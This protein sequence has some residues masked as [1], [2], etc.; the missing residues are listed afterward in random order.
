MRFI[1]LKCVLLLFSVI[2]VFSQNSQEQLSLEPYWRQ[3]L[4]G[5]VLSL[6]SYQAQS[7]VVAL[8]G[9]NIRAYSTSGTPMWSIFSGGRIS[10]YVTRS[11]EGTSYFTRTNG[12]LIAVNRAGRELWR[13]SLEGPLSARI[14]TG[15]DSRLFVPT[16]G[17]IYCYTAS[18]NLL[19]TKTIEA[20]F[21]IAPKLDREGGIIFAL[22]NNE[23]HRMDHFGNTYVWKLYNTPAVLLSIESG[24][25]S[26]S[27]AGSRT[28]VKQNIIVIY[29]DGSMEIL[30]SAEDWF[31]TAQTEV[32]SAILPRLP[33]PPLAAACMGNNIAVT[34]S[35]GR[36]SLVSLDEKR[37]IWTGDTHIRELVNNRISMEPETEMIFDERGI[38]ILSKN[39]ATGFTH[40]GERLWH[41]N[42]QNTAAVPA[43]G[44]DGVLYSGGK[45]WILY[46][47]KIEDRLLLERNDIY[48]PFPEGTYGMGRPRIIDII[49]SHLTE[50]ETRI[51][52]DQINSAVNAGRVGVNEP[53]WT[54][55]LLTVSAGQYPLQVRLGAMNLLG[56]I[57][58]Q[59]TIPWLINIFNNNKEPVIKSAAVNAIGSIGVDPQGIAI[60]AFLY[61]II[62]SSNM[63]EQVLTA[64]ASATGALCRFSGPPL[65]ETG[66]RILLAISQR[67]QPSVARRQAER[68]LATL[69]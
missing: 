63:D 46:A 54:S 23:I 20:P 49:D 51:R 43:F 39:G 62:N 30:E 24:G 2:P 10:P 5:E 8:D 37:I 4:G 32:H 33:S 64:I 52:L 22:N 60:Q 16:N 31:F 48:G 13:R 58:S 28:A 6:P 21:S 47:Y 65:S 68:E 7:V 1:Q 25:E 42:L 34:M 44:N 18:G 26:D 50:L 45:D 69:R 9:G 38:Y 12:T 17:K 14:I 40:N 36:V 56:M 19:W 61:S 53:A 55:F 35:D 29:T 3:A 41:M 27:R 66:I 11:R 67:H 15:W 57:G 59:E